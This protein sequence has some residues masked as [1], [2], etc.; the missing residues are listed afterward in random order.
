MTK[1]N[2]I[3]QEIKAY[4]YVASLQAQTKYEFQIGYKVME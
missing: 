1:Q 3:Y 2:S 4:M